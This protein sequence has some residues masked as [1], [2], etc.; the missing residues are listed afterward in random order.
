MKATIKCLSLSEE[1]IVESTTDAA[2]E[3]NMT[4]S[5]A[6]KTNNR[7]IKNDE[8]NGMEMRMQVILL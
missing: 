2:D 3:N 4:S 5:S 6:I 1:L 8:A 7:I